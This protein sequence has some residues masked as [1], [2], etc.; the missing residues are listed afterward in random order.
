MQAYSLQFSEGKEP[1]LPAA[2]NARQVPELASSLSLG[3]H[4]M[5]CPNADKIMPVGS[6]CQGFPGFFSER[7]CYQKS[8]SYI[9]FRKNCFKNKA[10][11]VT[12]L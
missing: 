2:R 9:L 12:F 11:K 7:F 1:R 4:K 3:G 10:K 8:I 5:L 6:H